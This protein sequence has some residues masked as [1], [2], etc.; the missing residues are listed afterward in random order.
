MIILLGEIEF[1]MSNQLVYLKNSIY[2]SSAKHILP[3]F[4]S[5]VF[6]YLQH[7][8][9]TA[10]KDLTNIMT[11][12]ANSYLDDYFAIVL[13]SSNLSTFARDIVSRDM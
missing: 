4:I 7:D 9:I 11:S 10:L 5:D 2:D 3:T 8:D 1:V 13:S 6:Y 12:I